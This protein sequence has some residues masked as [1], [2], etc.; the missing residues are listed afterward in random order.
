MVAI[1]QGRLHG[2]HLKTAVRLE[3]LC[4]TNFL[5]SYLVI[6]EAWTSFFFLNWRRSTR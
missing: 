2:T 3:R 4:L 6:E 5:W 1:D